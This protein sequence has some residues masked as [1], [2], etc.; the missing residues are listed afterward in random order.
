[1]SIFLQTLI[2]IV[3]IGALS[4]PV[5]YGLSKAQMKGWINAI[6]EH[7]VNKVKNNQNER[8]KEE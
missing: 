2:I 8:E 4:I 7:F 5:K 1:M 6:E 3:L